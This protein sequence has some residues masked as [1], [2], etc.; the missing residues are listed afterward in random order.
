MLYKIY[1]QLLIVLLR[2]TAQRLWG[3]PDFKTQKPS[4]PW[5]CQLKINISSQLCFPLKYLEPLKWKKWAMWP[6]WSFVIPTFTLLDHLPPVYF[7]NL[8][9]FCLI[10]H[11]STH[12][13]SMSLS[14]LDTCII[15]EVCYLLNVLYF[16]AWFLNTLCWNVQWSFLELSV[17]RNAGFLV[18]S[19]VGWL[20]PSK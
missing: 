14:N 4:F 20:P 17:Q 1:V 16:T 13:T 3:K 18:C 2:K 19:Q 6:S 5:S 11:S 7:F 12:K 8:F 10:Q 15:S 9:R